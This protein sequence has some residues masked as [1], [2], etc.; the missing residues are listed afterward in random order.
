MTLRPPTLGLASEDTELVRGNRSFRAGDYEQAVRQ[1]GAAMRQRPPLATLIAFNLTLARRRYRAQRASAATLRVGV[2]GWE[3]AHNAAGRVHTLVDLY[4]RFAETEVVGFFFPG[5]GGRLWEPVRGTTTPHHV[6]EVESATSF[7]DEALELVLR[8]PYDVVHLSKA[9]APNLVVGLLYRLVWDAKVVMDVDDE[10]LSFVAPKTPLDVEAFLAEMP[11]AAS[12]SDLAGAAWTRLTSSLC[13]EFDGV[14]VS[15]RELQGRYGGSIVPHARDEQVFQPSPELRESSRSK[16]GIPK[17]K[18]VVLFFGT[19]RRHKGL[20]RVAN[21]IGSLHRNDVLF[22]IVGDFNDEKLKADLLGIS[23]VDYKF[24]GNQPYSSIP[25]VVAMGDICVLLQDTKKVVTQFQSPAK[26]T[27]ALAMGLVVLTTP[28]GPIEDALAAG[29]CVEVQAN[30]LAAQ[31]ARFIGDAEARARQQQAAHAYFRRELASDVVGAELQRYVARTSVRATTPLLTR[32]VEESS[33]LPAWFS[34]LFERAQPAAPQAATAARERSKNAYW[35]LYDEIT[36]GHQSAELRDAERATER[37]LARLRRQH[38]RRAEQPLVSVVMPTHNRSAIIGRSVATVLEQSYANLEL[39]VC[40]DASDDDTEQVLGRIGDGRL[41]YLKLPKGGAAA[42]RNAGLLAARGSVM[43]YLDSD[44]YWH[45]DYLLAMVTSLLEAPG[46]SAIYCDFLDFH[47]DTQGAITFMSFVRPPFSHESLLERPFIDLNSFIHFR[48]LYDCFGG[49]NSELKRRQDYDLILKFTWLRDPLHLQCMLTL[50]QRNDNLTQITTAERKDQTSVKLIRGT[51]EQYFKSGLPPRS[52][53]WPRKVTVLSWDMGRNHFAKPFAVA[54]ALAPRFDVQLLSF[55][56]FKE[57]IFK[58]LKNVEPGFETV[59]L[60]GSDFP[61]FFDGI[62][63][64]LSRIDGDIVYVVKP[65]LPSLGLALLANSRKGVPIVLEI[66]DLETVV[67]EPTEA[68]QHAAADFSTAKLDD[69]ELLNPYSDLWSQLMDPLARQLPLLVTHNQGIDRHFDRRCLY[70]RNAKDEK[71]YD[72]S[73]Y[74]RDRIRAKLGFR[75]EDRVILFGGLLRKHKGIYELIELLQRLEDPRYKLLFVGSRSTPDQIQLL[76]EYGDVVKVLPPQDREMM[77]RINLASDLVILWLNPDVAASHYQFPYKA[78]D[79]LAMGTP[80]IANDISDLGD[81]ARQGY[82]KTV[83]FGDWDAMTR[84]VREL[85]DDPAG[86]EQMRQAGRRLFLRQFSYAAVRSDFALI[87][88]RA[89]QNGKG[90]LPVAEQFAR[91]F[92]E[93]ARHLRGKPIAGASLPAAQL[94]LAFSGPV[95]I[96]IKNPAPLGANQKKWGDYHFGRCL[97]KYLQRLGAEVETHY[98]DDW[99]RPSDADAVLVLRGKHRYQPAGSAIHLLWCMSNPS[100]ITVGECQEYDAV[101]VAS[102]TH[103]AQLAKRTSTPVAPLLQCTDLEEFEGVEADVRD[104]TI[105]VGN[106]RGVRRP[107]IDWAVES[108]VELSIY[109]RGWKDFGLQQH[110]VADYI[111]NEDLPALYRRARFT[112]NDH[113]QDMKQMGYVNNRI[114]D[115]LA[116]GLPIVSDD[117]PEL[118]AICGDDILYYQD[119]PSLQTALRTIEADYAGVAA[120][121]RRLWQSIRQSFSFESRARTL[122]DMAATLRETKR[123]SPSTPNASPPPRRGAKTPGRLEDIRRAWQA[124]PS[125]HYCPVCGN[126]SPAFISGGVV[127]KRHNAKCPR[128]GAFERHRLFWLYYVNDLSPRLPT[129]LKQLLHVAPEEHIGQLLHSADDINYLS[130]DLFMPN[131]MVRLDLIAI[132]FPDNR[133]DVIVCSHIL[134]HIPDDAKA[135]REM[136]RVTRPGGF[137]LVMVP[138][139]GERTY[140]DSS[141]ITPEGRLQHFGQDDHVRKY[142]EDIE[143]RLTAAGFE[144]TPRRFAREVGRE[145]AAYAALKSQVI[146]ECRKP[147]AG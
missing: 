124:D 127:K 101:Y 114:F 96:V 10:E 62:E 12:L 136:F 131:V 8:H 130:G 58:P 6:V 15:N 111:A 123:Q 85:F 57:Q 9:R 83:P 71:V 16:F 41:R 30:T 76:A 143:Q 139:Y 54:E 77:A 23:G 32:F 93:F 44:N 106:S 49:F 132:D 144:V 105:F 22:V 51:V 112:L 108:G 98:H 2:C 121:Q 91:R 110:V 119:K 90:A 104:G 87:A 118:R 82:M 31:L 122:F 64:A 142:G 68:D 65:R 7:F 38:G 37:T 137:V 80:I 94:A 53:A 35:R 61:A 92:D 88:H 26:L 146:Y 84:T 47:V 113:W 20:T 95:K 29:A 97:S 59:Y 17:D 50:Y 109:G 63:E 11:D 5:F 138:L 18:H 60:P 107:C 125:G 40:D 86:T 134:E 42:A 129:R 25:E 36:R 116:A 141:I 75:P 67:G 81:L 27:D 33:I 55:R 140:E 45:P 72:P 79:A 120:R 128:C 14:T 52:V 28:T 13:R 102:T 117:F 147:V 19:P 34:P 39:I 145:I 70:L 126:V 48:E 56:F 21:A 69:P 78:T 99:Q 115:C 73:L 103:A 24:I 135:M 100:T 74:D 3:L 4:K 133:F 1:Y 46:H 89:A 66:N 43:V